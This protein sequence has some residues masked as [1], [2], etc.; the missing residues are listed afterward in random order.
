MILVFIIYYANSNLAKL[1]VK[2]V[3]KVPCL[4]GH[5]LKGIKLE[6][7]RIRFPNT[8]F[9]RQ[10]IFRRCSYFCVDVITL[11]HLVTYK[12]LIFRIYF[13]KK[14]INIDTRKILTNHGGFKVYKH[15]PG[16][17][18]PGPGLAEKRIERIVS[19]SNSF[20]ARHLTVGLN[21]VFKAIEFPAGIADL[22]PGLTNVDGYTLTL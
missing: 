3:A 16:H 7:S 18:F 8:L 10:K 5:F 6:Q 13:S 21:P 12:S 22:N 20:V 4:G 14:K 15:S 1:A 11:V 2:C 9:L 19:T 17:M